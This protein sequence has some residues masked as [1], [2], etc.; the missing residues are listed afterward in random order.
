M[1]PW[2]LNVLSA[3]KLQLIVLTKV[4]KCERCAENA[5]IAI[6]ERALKLLVEE[7]PNKFQ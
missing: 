6:P 1:W 4:V 5:M 7:D 3:S 2:H